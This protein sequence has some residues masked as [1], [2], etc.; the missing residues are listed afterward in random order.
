MFF[1]VLNILLFHPA[2][3]CIIF[4]LSLL[5]TRTGHSRESGTGVGWVG[6]EFVLGPFCNF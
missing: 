3:A 2:C 4:S 6:W 5:Y 1:V